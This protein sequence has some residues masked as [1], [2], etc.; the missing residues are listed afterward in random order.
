MIRP[1]TRDEISEFKP[2]LRDGIMVE[3]EDNIDGFIDCAPP[4]KRL[5]V[6]NVNDYEPAEG[7]RFDG[8]KWEE[9]QGYFYAPATRDMWRLLYRVARVLL[10]GR[11]ATIPFTTGPHTFSLP[12]VAGIFPE[13]INR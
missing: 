12:I 5:L 6:V 7:E 1:I 8:E 3:I 2:C 11:A 9:R 10:S 13:I 4:V